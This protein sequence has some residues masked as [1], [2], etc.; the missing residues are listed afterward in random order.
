MGTTEFS[1]NSIDL[2]RLA[3]IESS[4]NPRAYNP[5]SQA[6][7]LMQITP[8]SLKDYNNYH[9]KEPV[10][11]DQLYDPTTNMQVAQWYIQQRIPQMLKA[12]KIPVTLDN[13][14]WA[15]NGGIGNVKINRMA[16]ETQ[17]YIR[18]YNAVQER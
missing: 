17:D 18:K 3:Q 1:P 5:K 15:Y 11:P 13:V 16:P 8:I 9:A 2:V 4:Q 6:R 14:L 12:F 10:S 7:G